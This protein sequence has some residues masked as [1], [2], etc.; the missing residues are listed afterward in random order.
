LARLSVRAHVFVSKD[1][2]FALMIVGPSFLAFASQRE[3][4]KPERT[5]LIHCKAFQARSRLC[6]DASNSRANLG[7]P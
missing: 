5:K 2:A 3:A 6:F 1:S 4:A 7:S